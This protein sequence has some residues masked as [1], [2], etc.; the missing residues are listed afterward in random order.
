MCEFYTNTYEH[1]DGRVRVQGQDVSFDRT[2]INMFYSLPNIDND[3]YVT[4]FS[5]QVN[6]EEIIGAL[7]KPGTTWKLSHGKPISF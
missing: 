6:Y 5:D 2:S 7:C 3:E 1:N 4:Y